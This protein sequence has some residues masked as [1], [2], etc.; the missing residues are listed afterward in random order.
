MRDF[1]TAGNDDA[2]EV[3]ATHRALW[4]RLVRLNRA[5]VADLRVSLRDCG[6]M[7][8]PQYD[9]LTALSR[10][11]DG[12]KMS[13]L[14]EALHVSNGNVTGIVERLVEHGLV[15][16]ASVPGDRRATLVRLTERGAAARADLA[17]CHDASLG[18][19]LRGLD[20]GRAAA[21]ISLLD[22]TAA[23]GLSSAP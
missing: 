22:A 12:L 6:D 21:L 2:L 4:A 10:A 13:A 20:S 8:L 9:V 18:R 3:D 19:S 17:A 16:R 14:S 5:V 11:P 1:A 23:G 7:T 15:A